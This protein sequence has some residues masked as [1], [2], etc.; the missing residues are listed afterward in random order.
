MY[1]VWTIRGISSAY[2]NNFLIRPR[3]TKA[4]DM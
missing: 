1:I 4:L 3:V 2:R